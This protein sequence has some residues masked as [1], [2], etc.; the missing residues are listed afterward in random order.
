MTISTPPPPPDSLL[1]SMYSGSFRIGRRLQVTSSI[2][3]LKQYPR[4]LGDNYEEGEQYKDKENRR[5]RKRMNS[6]EGE[7]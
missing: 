4:V 7:S 1:P 5:R 6:T 3:R 2:S